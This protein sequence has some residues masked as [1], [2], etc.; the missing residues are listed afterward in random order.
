MKS[1]HTHTHTKKVNL[2]SSF[3]PS[4]SL[5]I[6]VPSSSFSSSSPSSSS[7]SERSRGITSSCEIPIISGFFSAVPLHF[8]PAVTFKQTRTTL[9]HRPL[10]PGRSPFE[11]L[12]RE[13]SAAKTPEHEER[14]QNTTVALHTYRRTNKE[15]TAIFSS[16][17]SS[18]LSFVYVEDFW[19]RKH[20]RE[21]KQLYQVTIWDH[22]GL[23]L[24][25]SSQVIK[26]WLNVDITALLVT[27]SNSLI[28]RS[29]KI[30]DLVFIIWKL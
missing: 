4:K 23:Y 14:L 30:S 26:V 5:S 7:D 9:P 12:G 19:K 15:L 25:Y 13:V 2:P 1:I 6:S 18:I 27:E 28:I 8:S 3:L 17:N 16:W 24:V 11:H 22:A 29:G 10:P 21:W 20:L